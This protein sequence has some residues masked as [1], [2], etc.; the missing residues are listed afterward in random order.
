MLLRVLSSA[1]DKVSLQG[2][3]W[4]SGVKHLQANWHRI[5]QW[6]GSSILPHLVQFNFQA[7]SGASTGKNNKGASW[8]F[9]HAVKI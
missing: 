5:P 2:C 8:F 3:F 7:A 1:G 6:Q 4:K 9:M